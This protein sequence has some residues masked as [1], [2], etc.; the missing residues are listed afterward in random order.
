VGL[1]TSGTVLCVLLAR[2]TPGSVR[3]SNTLFLLVLLP[4][5]VLVWMADDARAVRGGNWVPYEP[6]K[7]SVLVL[8]M[9]A[10]PGW[11]TGTFAI[12]LFAGSALLH[13]FLFSEVA[14]ARLPPGVPFGIIAYGAF[15]LIVLGFRRRGHV[16][17]AELEQARSEK[18]ALARLQRVAISLRDLANTP[19][20]TLELVRRALLTDS[21][22]LPAQA[23]RMAHALEKLRVLN[24]ILRPYQNAVVQEEKR[25][26]TGER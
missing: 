21:P 10:P 11:K 24:D 3:L 9:I 14:R 12:L 26:T 25:L 2:R 1:L 23:D 5:I 17:R 8:A 16:L 15:A 19:L 4:T 6:I 13:Y 7:L 20:Q 18:V 22:N